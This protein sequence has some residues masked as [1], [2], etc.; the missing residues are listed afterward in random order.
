MAGNIMPGNPLGTTG[1]FQCLTFFAR[2]LSFLNQTISSTQSRFSPSDT[3]GNSTL[4]T[5]PLDASLHM[6]CSLIDLLLYILCILCA[7]LWSESWCP[8][9]DIGWLYVVN[10]T[11]FL[12][13]PAIPK[14]PRANFN[15]PAWWGPW[16]L[17]AWQGFP[18]QPSGGIGTIFRQT[19][20]SSPKNQIWG[21]NISFSAI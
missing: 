21:K 11:G 9:L 15:D 5:G 17:I 13:D 8:G 10:H 19:T 16:A 20:F 6:Q 7:I 1:P 18:K 3:G 12:T 2:Y 4:L 14:I